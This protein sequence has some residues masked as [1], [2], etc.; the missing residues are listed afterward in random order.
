MGEKSLE[1]RVQGSFRATVVDTLGNVTYSWIAGSIL[2]YCAG[3]NGEGI[4]VSRISAMGINAVTGR[5]YGLWRDYVFEK[6]RTTDESGRIQRGVVEL[7]AFNTFQVPIYAVGV[8][9]GTFVSEGEVNWTKV[10]EGSEYLAMI[11]PLIGPTMGW[12]M[13]G[14]RRMGGVKSAAERVEE[15]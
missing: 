14:F 7:V 1:S 10:K 15:K 9:I 5:P 3:L 4:M 13:D 6:M 12:Y 2:D 11:S 8:M